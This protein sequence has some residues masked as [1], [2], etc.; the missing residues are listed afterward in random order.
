M[1]NQVEPNFDNLETENIVNYLNSGGWATEN[2]VTKDFEQK[3]ASYVGMKFAVAVPSGTVALY[4]AILALNLK[5]G[6]RIAVPNHNYGSY[7]KCYFVGWTY[8]GNC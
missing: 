4:L 7:H 8:S 3:I 1:I 6:S 5:N 2:K